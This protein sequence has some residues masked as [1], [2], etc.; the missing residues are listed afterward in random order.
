[1]EQATSQAS[2]EPKISLEEMQATLAKTLK[3]LAEDL[4]NKTTQLQALQHDIEESSQE[5]QRLFQSFLTL[6][7]QESLPPNILTQKTPLEEILKQQ[8]KELQK[9]MGLSSKR[10]PQIS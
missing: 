9:A 4:Q 7:G 6:M 3:R 5:F 1:M 8:Q 2:H 10:D